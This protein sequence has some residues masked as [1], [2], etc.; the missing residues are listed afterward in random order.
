MAGDLELRYATDPWLSKF[1]AE[2]MGQND[3]RQ[4]RCNLIIKLLVICCWLLVYD[5][6]SVGIHRTITKA[7]ELSMVPTETFGFLSAIFS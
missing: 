2:V 5:H 1:L 3:R 4:R 6:R 7:S